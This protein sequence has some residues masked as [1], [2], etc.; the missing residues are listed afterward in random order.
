MTD[1]RH[2]EIPLSTDIL[3]KGYSESRR[4][5]GIQDLPELH[6]CPHCTEAQVRVPRAILG[7]EKSYRTT[8][9]VLYMR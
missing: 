6:P 1:A 2:H 7:V 9:T 5:N 4:T 3:K 8:V